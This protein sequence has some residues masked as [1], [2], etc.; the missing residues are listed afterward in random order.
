LSPSASDAAPGLHVKVDDSVAVFGAS[1]TELRT[2]LE[3]VIFTEAEPESVPPYPSTIS[4][5]HVSLSPEDTTVGLSV[6]EAVVASVFP[7]PSDHVYEIFGVSRSASD[8]L[9]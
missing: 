5:V 8:T 2:G 9:A 7:L 3:F 1:V 4:T 6:K